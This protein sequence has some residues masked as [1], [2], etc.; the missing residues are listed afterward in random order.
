MLIISNI[1]GILSYTIGEAAGM[2]RRVGQTHFYLSELS[3][4]YATF[5]NGG[6]GREFIAE[7][8]YGDHIA[9]HFWS[10]YFVESEI[11]GKK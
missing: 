3:G 9:F 2:Y 4:E 11:R 10:Q 1:A 6:T 5:Q 7:S 8:P